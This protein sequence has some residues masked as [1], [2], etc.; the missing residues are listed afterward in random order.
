[1]RSM[2]SFSSRRRCETSRVGRDVPGAKPLCLQQLR[3]VAQEVAHDLLDRLGCADRLHQA[4]LN[5]WHLRILSR[6]DWLC[7]SAQ[8]LIEARYRWQAKPTC[9]RSARDRQEIC[10]PLEAELARRSERRWCQAQRGDRQWA[11]RLY[12][13]AW[14]DAGK[15]VPSET[16]QRVRSTWCVGYRNT[17]CEAGATTEGEQATAEPLFPAMQVIATGQV[18]PKP[19][20]RRHCRNRRPAPD[21]QQR[22]AIE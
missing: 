3:E 1:M 5:G 14:F 2:R 21:R 10:D 15:I 16:G 11:Q 8:G 18:D 13:S 19:V 9:Q 20:C 22:K 7:H 6:G 4:A 12:R 17:G